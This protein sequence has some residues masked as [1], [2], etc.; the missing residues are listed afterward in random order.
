MENNRTEYASFKKWVLRRAVF[1]YEALTGLSHLI[2]A[3]FE[4]GFK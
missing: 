4:C 2:T 3:V 1:M